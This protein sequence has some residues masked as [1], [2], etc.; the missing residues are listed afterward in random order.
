MAEELTP[1][2]STSVVDGIQG[3]GG[4]DRYD[5]ANH[6]ARVAARTEEGRAKLAP[7]ID[8]KNVKPRWQSMSRAMHPWMKSTSR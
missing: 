4:A 2:T 6:W 8:L 5:W 1:P 3:G 7:A